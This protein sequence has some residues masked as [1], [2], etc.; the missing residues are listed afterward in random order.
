MWYLMVEGGG[1]GR[2]CF[3][4]GRVEQLRGG[5]WERWLGLWMKFGGVCCN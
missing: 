2:G 1:R 4:G 5:M 3:G